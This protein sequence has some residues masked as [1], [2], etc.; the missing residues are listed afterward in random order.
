MYLW[1]KAKNKIRVTFPNEAS[2]TVTGSGVL[3]EMSD[4]KLLLEFGLFQSNNIKKDFQ[5]NST[6]PPFKPKDIDYIFMLH[7]HIDHTGKVPFLY[8]NGCEAEL[9][10]PKGS[11]K[12]F[13]IMALDSSYIMSRDTEV[14]RK[15]YKMP[16]SPLYNDDDVYNT[17]DHI[18]EYEIGKIYELSDKIKFQFIHSGHILLSTMLILWLKEE[19]GSMKKINI[20]IRPRW[21][22]KKPYTHKRDMI[23]SCNL[24]IAESTYSDNTR[25][26]N[27]KDKVKDLQKIET[28]IKNT[29]CEKE[30]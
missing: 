17:V 26:V 21:R 25:T 8:A 23:P 27:K 19:S 11:S 30:K 1:Q 22:F 16:V 7:Q 5:I 4:C 13:S 14:L 6:K 3:I 2:S 29:C 10:A 18:K 20:Y 9:I 28:V 24:L 15:S 12:L